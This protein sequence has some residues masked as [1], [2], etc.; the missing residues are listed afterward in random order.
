MKPPGW[1]TLTY[2]GPDPRDDHVVLYSMR[3]KR[4]HPGW[5]LFVLRTLWRR[6]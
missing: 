5:W 2:L 4:W 1:M 3:V 6:R